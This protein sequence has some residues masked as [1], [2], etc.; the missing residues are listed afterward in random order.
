MGRYLAI[1]M[2]EYITN[3]DL[4][5]RGWCWAKAEL[6]RMGRYYEPD[7]DGNAYDVYTDVDWIGVISTVESKLLYN[8]EHD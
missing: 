4:G 8:V 1:G 2:K 3:P 7:E 5:G 6:G